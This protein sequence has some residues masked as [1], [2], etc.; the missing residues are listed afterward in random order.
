MFIIVSII[1]QSIFFLLPLFL[2]PS[3][4][5]ILTILPLPGFVIAHV[6]GTGIFESQ[7]KDLFNVTQSSVDEYTLILLVGCIVTLPAFLAGFYFK[8]DVIF[9]IHKLFLAFLPRP[10]GL[11]K[12]V[13][14][15][16]LSLITV[17]LFAYAY[18][19][20]GFAP[21]LTEKP[22]AARFFADEYEAAYRPYA[23][24]FRV[25]L[26]LSKI[27]IFTLLVRILNK[28]RLLDVSLVLALTFLLA[29]SAR[30]GLIFSSLLL[31]A[32]SYFSYNSKRLFWPVV[33]VYSVF[34]GVGSAIFTLASLFSS[35]S[36]NVDVGN[37]VLI[38][39]SGLPDVR[40]SLWFIDSWL[41]HGWQP[42]N[43]LSVIGG[44]FP[45]QFPYNPSIISKLV[46][47][48]KANAATGG[49]RLD[50][51]TLGYIAFSWPGVILF[52]ALYG[53]LSGATLQVYKTI[54]SQVKNLQGF[55]ICTFLFQELFGLTGF[56]FNMK[57]DYIAEVLTVAFIFLSTRIKV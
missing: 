35:S 24:I 50:L 5:N 19:K 18:I 15:V 12:G 28:F 37:F 20:I 51:A 43:G 14:P 47:G 27:C 55:L 39:I 36:A 41:I 7:A 16:I 34:T 9:L 23:G 49:F 40:D 46:I 8:S 3:R 26:L 31:V 21:L 44:L 33:S 53:Y 38:L 25:S 13:I 6:I 22:E 10:S 32:L 2:W 57:I 54:V 52:S 11:L 45:E 30:R 42:T 4:R 17:A 56:I 1:Y 29:L 48:S